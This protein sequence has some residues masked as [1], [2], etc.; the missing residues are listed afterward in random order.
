MGTMEK[1][2]QTSPYFLAAFAILFVGF[3]VASDADISNLINKRGS[4]ATEVIGSVNGEDILYKDFDQKVKELM[5]QKRKQTSDPNAQI[6]EDQIINQVWS[7]MVDETLLKQEAKKAGVMVSDEEILD[8]MLD[9][10]PD[11]LRK[12]FTDSAGN[13]NKQAYLEIVTDPEK[14][15]GALGTN[16]SEEEKQ[17]IIEDFKVNLI[18]IEKYLRQQKLAEGLIGV[19]SSSVSQVS[20]LYAKEKYIYD[21]TSSDVDF[22]YFGRDQ[23]Q[24]N[25]IQV[26]EKD[27]ADYY[28]KHK[29]SFKQKPQRRLKYIKFDIA[30]SVDDTIR[31][32][33]KVDRITADLNSVTSLLAK[34]SVFDLKMGEYGGSTQDFQLIKDIPEYKL[35]LLQK[36]NKNDIVGPVM[37]PNGIIYLRLDDTRSGTNEV[38]KASHIL[39]NFSK[40]KDSAKAEADMIMAKAKAGEDFATLARQYS[41]DKGSAAQGG[42]LGYF[43]KG[44]MVKPFEDAAFAAE[45]GF[46]VGPVE[47]QFGY[48]IIKVVDK[49]SDEMKYSE[50]II[51]PTVSTTTKNMIFRNAYAF[52]KQVEEGNSFDNLAEKSKYKVQQTMFFTKG[53]PVLSSQY[54]SDLAFDSESGTCFQPTELK[55]Q[56]VFVCMVSDIREDKYRPLKDMKEYIKAQVTNIKKLDVLK[57]KAA[58]AYSKISGLDALSKAGTIDPSL[59]VKSL[60]GVQNTGNVQGIGEDFVFTTNATNLPIQTISEPI[61]GTMGYYIM[62]VKSRVSPPTES[63]NTGYLQYISKMKKDNYQKEFYQW[64]GKVKEN[65]TIVD[66]RMK[67]YRDY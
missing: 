67:F 61:R 45:P 9:N 46:I 18:N 65:A 36:M 8:V 52:Q 22:L 28:D 11:Y 24:D 60:A 64:F 35:N 20:P 2:R 62:Q 16:V 21:Y 50:I 40:G 7:Q 59:T 54:L 19:V 23:I 32:G 27:I 34:D 25:Q 47:S 41:Q 56:G 55:N 53:T 63:V 14:I 15:R 26:T 5:E 39:I 6:D 17:K 30:P 1:M 38:V 31:A 33:K 3:M 48:H 37:I 29:E 13:F 43:A 10:P 42:D 51:N 58:D 12:S 49:K 4:I 44:A 66:Q 57:S